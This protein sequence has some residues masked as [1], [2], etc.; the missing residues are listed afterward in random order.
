MEVCFE[1]LGNKQNFDND[2]LKICFKVYVVTEYL[3]IM[4]QT[5]G[6]FTH[7]AGRQLLA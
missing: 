4:S 5:D 7:V 6:R 3:G 1:K 2:L